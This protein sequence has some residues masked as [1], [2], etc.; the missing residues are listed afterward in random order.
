MRAAASQASGGSPGR[1][2]APSDVSAHIEADRASVASR[3]SSSAPSSRRT[4][5]SSAA[6]ADTCTALKMCI[7]L[8][9]AGAVIGRG[10]GTVRSLSGATHTAI[11]IQSLDALPAGARDREL[12]ITGKA[13]SI[14][15]A[16]VL[17]LEVLKAAAEA[18]DTCVPPI[19]VPDEVA[20]D[21]V[22][23]GGD[24]IAAETGARIRVSPRGE[25]G[26]G[27]RLVFVNGT[28]EAVA[29]ACAAIDKISRKYPTPEAVK[30]DAPGAVERD[31]SRKVVLPHLAVGFLIG[32]RGATVRN[33]TAASGARIQVLGEADLRA[34]STMR[35]A[36]LRGSLQSIA[37]AK[38][39]M[40]AKLASRGK[41]A[42]A[43]DAN[44][45][46]QKMV[47][48][49]F[50]VDDVLGTETTQAIRRETG[51]LIKFFDGDNFSATG[52]MRDTD[53][54]VLLVGTIAV[55]SKAT[56]RILLVVAADE[57]ANARY[58]AELGITSPMHNAR[59]PYAWAPLGFAAPQHWMLHVPLDGS[60]PYGMAHHVGG[61]V[62]AAPAAP[63]PF[64][65]DFGVPYAAHYG[66]PP[67][68]L[69]LGHSLPGA[70]VPYGCVPAVTEAYAAP[71]YYNSMAG[72]PYLPAS[73]HHYPGYGHMPGLAASG[74]AT[75]PYPMYHVAGGR[76]GSPAIPVVERPAGD[77]VAYPGGAT[78]EAAAAAAADA[79]A[80]ATAKYASAA[81][82]EAAPGG[83]PPAH[84]AAHT[85]RAEAGAN[86][87]RPATRDSENDGSAGQQRQQLLISR[88]SAD[89]KGRA[90]SA[91]AHPGHAPATQPHLSDT[92]R[93]TA[94]S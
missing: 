35:A 55:I 75:L 91:G 74:T 26:D 94:A 83:R 84:P 51:C 37:K 79:R 90:S 70:P 30:P 71:A 77:G 43:A 56:E 19:P 34:G 25:G 50:V 16:M 45:V 58:Q 87:E 64:A 68:G 59:D 81:A 47:L 12:T 33:I 61:G 5:T 62:H 17:L 93:L 88:K 85:H 48:P 38:E 11:H 46:A 54:L 63:P 29:A 41:A 73:G 18:H 36:V 4:S 76:P 10:G 13:E 89:G 22:T 2:H 86:T 67:H 92:A 28:K 60:A 9:T 23:G 21:L 40:E 57:G 20:E 14:C 8:D 52:G 27:A 3:A 72:H 65:Q 32:R 39:L 69:P 1:D 80:R 15:A 24:A 31:H 66:P 78:A 53:C 7:P 49:K 82:G 6:A 42:L 44:V